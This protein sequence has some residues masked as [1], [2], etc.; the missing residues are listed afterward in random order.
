MYMKICTNCNVCI[1]F[2]NAL[3]HVGHNIVEKSFQQLYEE[4]FKKK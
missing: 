3:L 1:N 2:E 4:A